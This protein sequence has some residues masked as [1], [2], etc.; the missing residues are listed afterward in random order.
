M[1]TPAPSITVFHT[2]INYAAVVELRSSFFTQSYRL[3]RCIYD[4]SAF[5]DLLSRLG[6][7]KWKR[8]PRGAL[9]VIS[10][11]LIAHF[12]DN[13]LTIKDKKEVSIGSL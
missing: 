13:K 1:L 3:T 4:E 12:A 9:K 5:D 2:A 7:S 6:K 11:F 10:S 8:A